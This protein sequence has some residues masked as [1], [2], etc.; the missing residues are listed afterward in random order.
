M[1]RRS[2]WM[3]VALA[4]FALTLTAMVAVTAQAEQK[5]IEF[6]KVLKVEDLTDEELQK[7]PAD[8]A[9][10][11][12][13]RRMTVGEYRA[14]IDDNKSI[15]SSEGKSPK[16]GQP[17]SIG[18]KG[19]VIRMEELSEKKLKTLPS[20]QVIEHQGKQLAVGEIR[21]NQ[22]SRH[23]AVPRQVSRSSRQSSSGSRRPNWSPRTPRFGPSWP[24]RRS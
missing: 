10:E 6:K 20:N 14:I 17:K 1:N 8:Q 13:G 21:A 15:R 7:L 22:G 4:V 24:S 16:P 11:Y 12:K 18:A 5:K 9:V 19:N 3:P 23:V 2:R